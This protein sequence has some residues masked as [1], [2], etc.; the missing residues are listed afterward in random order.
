MY[1]KLKTLA[2]LVI[3]KDQSSHL[4]YLIICI[5]KQTCENLSSIGHRSCEIVM[6]GKTP[7]SHEVVCFRMLDFVTTTSNSE[8]SKSNSLEN[9]FFLENYVT[10]EGAVSHNT[11]YYQQ[12]PITRYQVRFYAYTY[13]E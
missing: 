8:V 9:Y 12:L 13:F 2:V 5:N 6:K 3:V 1:F 4:V 10:S 11:L 7:L